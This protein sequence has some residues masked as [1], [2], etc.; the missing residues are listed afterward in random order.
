MLR[1]EEEAMAAVDEAAPGEENGMD[2]DE[3]APPPPVAVTVEAV[4]QVAITAAAAAEEVVTQ[5][6]VGRVRRSACTAS[7]A[8][9]H[10]AASVRAARHAARALEYLGVT[11]RASPARKATT[12]ER[13][14]AALALPPPLTGTLRSST[15]SGWSR[16]T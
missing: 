16:D 4:V 2:A 11:S 12:Y 3:D 6:A 10:Q 5:A 1:F 9:S 7:S 15:R 8:L 14:A 13:R